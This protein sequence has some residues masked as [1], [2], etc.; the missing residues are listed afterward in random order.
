MGPDEAENSGDGEKGVS[1][2]GDKCKTAVGVDDS[3]WHK[4]DRDKDL[5]DEQAAE[6]RWYNGAWAWVMENKRPVV[7]V[8][9]RGSLGIYE[10]A[11]ELIEAD[12]FNCNGCR[13]GCELDGTCF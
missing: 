10:V 1:Y 11:D 3:G 8:H 5:A 12:C 6:C 2:E 4:D 7:P 13:A 9:I